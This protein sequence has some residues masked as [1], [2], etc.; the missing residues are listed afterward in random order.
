LISTGRLFASFVRGR[1]RLDVLGVQ[2]DG[3][4]CDPQLRLRA[5]QACAPASHVPRIADLDS[6]RFGSAA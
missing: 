1:K 4:D 3:N 5:S 2:T 6:F